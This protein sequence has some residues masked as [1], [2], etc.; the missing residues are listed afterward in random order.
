MGYTDC[1]VGQSLNHSVLV[2]DLTQPVG[3]RAIDHSRRL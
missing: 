3:I 2:Q 1:R